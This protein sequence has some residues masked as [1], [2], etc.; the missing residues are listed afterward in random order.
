MTETQESGW[1]RRD[2]IGGAALLALA[3]GVP[4]AAVRMSSLDPADAPTEA[5]RGLL[6]EVSQLVLPRT[7]TPGAGEVGVGDFVALALA[8]G[9]EKSRQ[10]LDDNA[11]P[12]LLR[13]RR[14]DG[15]LDHVTWLAAELERRAG[16]D[17][18]M[19]ASDA[20]VAALTALDAE[21]FGP[22]AKT[23]PWRTLKAL[24]LTGYYTSEVGGAQELRF[25][26][27]PGRFDPDLP[28]QPGDRAWSSD[29]TAVDFG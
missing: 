9:L 19:A 17:F 23:H 4:L 3:L 12:R 28:L 29:W 24:I 15:S 2:F 22:E 5:Q 10:P 6:R 25:E 13:F 7:G 8:H 11:D 14:G 1:N 16:M 21:A 20:R 18:L 27:V 26:L